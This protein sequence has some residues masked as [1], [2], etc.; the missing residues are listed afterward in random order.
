MIQCLIGVCLPFLIGYIKA[1]VFSKGNLVFQHCTVAH[2]CLQGLSGKQIS[3]N[4]NLNQ[5]FTS[6][7]CVHTGSGTSHQLL[8]VRTR[9][10]QSFSDCSACLGSKTRLDWFGFGTVRDKIPSPPYLVKLDLSAD[11]KVRFMWFGKKKFCL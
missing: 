7:P 5:V 3:L 2:C 9:N 8:K 1:F 6:N 11:R 10:R 4:R